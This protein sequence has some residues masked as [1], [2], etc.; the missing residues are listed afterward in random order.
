VFKITPTGKLT[1]LYNF[2]NPQG[3][4][5]TSGLTLATNGKLYGTASLGGASSH[6]TLFKITPTGTLIT[7]YNFTGGNDGGFP[8][9]PPIQGTDGNPY[10][11][12]SGGGQFSCGTV[13]KVTR[14]GKVITLHEFDGKHGCS[15]ASPLIL[16]TDGNFYG[17]TRTGGNANYGVIFKVTPTGRIT[18]F[19]DNAATI[20]T[21]AYTGAM[22][23]VGQKRSK[24]EI[25]VLAAESGC[26]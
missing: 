11:T 12:M 16:W 3:I 2:D 9:G 15:P 4:D 22:L 13:Y 20:Y 18:A 6:G 8:Y 7:L 17:I 21:I 1:V 24:E 19:Q 14:A 23:Q 25:A 5:P 10:G 26:D